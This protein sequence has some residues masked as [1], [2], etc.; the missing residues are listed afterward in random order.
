MSRAITDTS[1][2]LL[3]AGVLSGCGQLIG[4]SDLEY[5]LDEDGGST[6]P[7]IFADCAGTAGPTP[8]NIE[9]K[10][11]IDSTEVTNAQYEEF[12]D[13]GEPVEQPVV[14]EWNQTEGSFAAFEP[15]LLW[16]ADNDLANVA[17]RMVDWC[18]AWS[19]CHWAG[20][21]LC[22]RV[23]GAPGD[24]EDVITDRSELYYACTQGGELEYPYGNEF[25]EAAC[26]SAGQPGPGPVASAPGCEGGY[27]GVFDLSGNVAEWTGL[28]ADSMG[29]DDYCQI[30][31]AGFNAQPYDPGG[32]RIWA[33]NWAAPA[34]RKDFHE[35]GF[36]CCSDVL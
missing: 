28:C 34:R 12:L 22:G 15:A 21:R 8:V 13:A 18:D 4:A 31:P 29:A 16:P 36:R 19:Y 32:I 10:F 17:V 1:L 26:V 23:G 7:G 5:T 9:G 3:L 33:C 2:A 14:C 20:K 30:G 6:A 11:C 27:P 35:T 24:F 25:D